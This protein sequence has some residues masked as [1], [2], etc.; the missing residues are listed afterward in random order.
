MASA[1]GG[2]HLVWSQADEAGNYDI[3]YAHRDGRD[4]GA[5]VRLTDSPEVDTLPA[6]A[7]G[8]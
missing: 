2:V 3:Y 7:E 5:P 6:V 8:P 1:S 4:W